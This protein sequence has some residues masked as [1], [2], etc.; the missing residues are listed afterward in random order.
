LYQEVPC[1]NDDI[2]SVDLDPNHPWRFF[3]PRYPSTQGYP[4]NVACGW[5]FRIDSHKVDKISV[6][7]DHIN[8]VGNYFNDC[9]GGDYLLI[10]HEDDF[11]EIDAPGRLCGD[12]SSWIPLNSSIH[13]NS[14]HG[15][16]QRYFF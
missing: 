14:D 4:H 6:M 1:S 5:K 15:Q 16:E 3:S 7:C 8:I 12:L 10:R 13:I 2:Q 11:D 9:I